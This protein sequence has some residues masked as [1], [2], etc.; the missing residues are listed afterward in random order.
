MRRRAFTLIELLVV[1]AIIAILAA[2]LFPVFAQARARA[3]QSA[4]LSNS[5]QMSMGVLMYVVDYDGLFPLTVPGG[6]RAAFVTPADIT[7]TT[8][9]AMARRFS[10]WSNSIQPYVRNWGVY[11]CPDHEIRDFWGMGTASGVVIGLL[12]NGYLNQWSEAFSPAPARV[13]M[14]S[15]GMGR[16]SMPGI[17]N[18]FP[19]ASFGNACGW[20]Q[21]G[22]AEA[23][24][25]FRASGDGCTGTCHMS[26][27]L[28]RSWWVHGEGSNY[29]Y[30]D[31]HARWVRNPS[32]LSPW[33]E[34]DANGLP[35]RAWLNAEPGCQWYWAYGP[36]IQ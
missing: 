26:Y 17:G 30:M 33:A 24:W 14:F 31:G 18:A 1:I 13:I 2:I 8:P 32:A 4:C 21:G 25:R 3:R 22:A 5:K 6:R 15:E 28:D 7:A 23:V 36:T 20:T 27:N 12:L 11:T 10:Y 35:T 19:L 9:A 16:Q 29:V 34:V